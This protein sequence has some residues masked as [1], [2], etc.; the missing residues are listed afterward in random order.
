[1]TLETSLGRWLVEDLDATQPGVQTQLKDGQGE[2]M[3]AA[4][5]REGVGEVRVTSGALVQ[6]GRVA[7]LPVAAAAHRGR[8]PRGTHRPAL[9]LQGRAGAGDA[10]GRLRAGAQGHLDLRR[11]RA[12]HAPARAPPSSC[13]AR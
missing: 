10:G 9:A 12:Q 6:T 5:P 3:L 13:R 2:F 8:H 4:S 7:F 11:Q 1:M